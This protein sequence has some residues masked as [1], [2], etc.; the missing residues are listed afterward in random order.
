MAVTKRDEMMSDEF[1]KF[2]AVVRKVFSVSH[3]EIVKRE[4]AYQRKRKHVKQKRA[5]KKRKTDG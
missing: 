2:D 5:D 3:D 1:S 4:K